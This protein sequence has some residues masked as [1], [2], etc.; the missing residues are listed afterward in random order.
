MLYIYIYVLC[1]Y[2]YMYYVYIYIY[3]HTY[4]SLYN[5]YPRK[6]EGAQ[7]GGSHGSLK[8]SCYIYIYIYSN[9]LLNKTKLL[10]GL[11]V[12]WD[13]YIYIYTHIH[14]HVKNTSKNTYYDKKLI[15]SHRSP[16]SVCHARKPSGRGV[17]QIRSFRPR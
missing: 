10:N 6:E 5:M 2:V 4:I 13:T 8:A 16:S 3:I 15:I 1:I 12:Y 11:S 9:S 7:Q 17:S 14:T